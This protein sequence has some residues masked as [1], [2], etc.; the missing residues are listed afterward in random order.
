L[1][2]QN[3]MKKLFSILLLFITTVSFGQQYWKFKSTADSVEVGSE[4]KA[5][6]EID[7]TK[8]KDLDKIS[9]YVWDTKIERTSNLF[10]ISFVV[11]LKGA[12]KYD[13]RVINNSDTIKFQKIVYGIK[14]KNP[15]PSVSVVPLPEKMPE[16]K[17]KTYTSFDDYIIRSLK[18]ENI[19]VTGKLILTYTIMA[20]GKITDIK[21]HN[22]TLNYL[23]KDKI[24]II[25]ADSKSWTPG[26]DKGKNVNVPIQNLFDFK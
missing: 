5:F 4:F 25:I 8:V 15:K 23:D 12:L 18:K 11:F 24:S 2:R 1:D 6:I 13:L 9:V 7:T 19:S 10:P 20:D 21:V 17:S 3:T 22:K 14:Q 26:K 16:Y